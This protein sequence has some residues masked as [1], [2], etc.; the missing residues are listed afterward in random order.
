MQFGRLICSIP[1]IPDYHLFYV[2]LIESNLDFLCFCRNIYW[3]LR[4]NSIGWLLYTLFIQIAPLSITSYAW[5]SLNLNLWWPPSYLLIAFLLT[6]GKIFHHLHLDLLQFSVSS[7]LKQPGNL[8]LNNGI[9]I[10][11]FSKSKNN[12]IQDIE[13]KSFEFHLRAIFAC[14]KYW[15]INNSLM[16]KFHCMEIIFKRMAN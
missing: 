16:I 3:I 14:I 2:F 12:Y 8:T 6:Y 15:R 10:E 13:R 9:H 7:N 1:P 11:L 5:W 4:Y